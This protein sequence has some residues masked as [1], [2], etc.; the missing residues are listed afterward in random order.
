MKTFNFLLE[1]QLLPKSLTEKQKLV[2]SYLLD[3]ND[4]ADIAA[5]IGR[6]VKTVKA[7]ITGL[8]AAFAVD[9][10][11]QIVCLCMRVH[12]DALE[13]KSPDLAYEH[14]NHMEQAHG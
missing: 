5:A 12:L 8:I 1:R 9:S 6:D 13:G 2:L 4:N 7:H 11:T 14:Q 10:R 3:G